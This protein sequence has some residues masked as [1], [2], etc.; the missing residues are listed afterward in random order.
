[1]IDVMSAARRSLTMSRIK[2]RNTRPELLVRRALHSKGFRYVL[3][4]HSLPGS[5]DIVLSKYKAVVFV[6]G[7]FWHAHEGCRFA[8]IPATRREFW[9]SKFERNK[10]RDQAAV[11]S[12]LEKGWRVVIVWECALRG[13]RDIDIGVLTDFLMSDQVFMEI[14]PGRSPRGS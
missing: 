4:K 12:L 8:A 6:H 2:G 14:P 3:H 9:V 13:R 10:A 7:C 5:P 1:M 11:S